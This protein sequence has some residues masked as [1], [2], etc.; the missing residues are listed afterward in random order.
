MKI[1][2]AH[3]YLRQ[4]SG[5]NTVYEKEKEL[6][7]AKEDL[8]DTLNTMPDFVSVHDRDFTVTKVNNALCEFLN[9]RP[10]KLIGN[11]CYQVFHD[12]SEPYK[13]CP[14]EKTSEPPDFYQKYIPRGHGQ[15]IILK[16]RKGCR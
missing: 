2:L 3:N 9:K 13:N 14:H 1:L 11:K 4:P 16:I 6:L 15:L 5:E 7:K 12:T 8:E 10:E